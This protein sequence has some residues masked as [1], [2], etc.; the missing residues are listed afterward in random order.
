MTWTPRRQ[1]TLALV[2]LAVSIVCLAFNVY[3]A[4]STRESYLGL[5]E[6]HRRGPATD[7]RGL[8]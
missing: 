4:N 2:A 3:F 5:K 7:P 8:R 6:L 1:M